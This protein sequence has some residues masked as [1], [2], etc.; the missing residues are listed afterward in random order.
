MWLSLI[1]LQEA[2]LRE[3][4]AT[5]QAQSGAAL[6]ALVNVLNQSTS[7]LTGSSV[8]TGL[9]SWTNSLAARLGYKVVP[10]AL[11]PATELEQVEK[12]LL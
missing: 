4:V 7:N 8:T 6:A 10:I 9:L 2:Q 3:Y 1:S 5:V 12:A 11:Q